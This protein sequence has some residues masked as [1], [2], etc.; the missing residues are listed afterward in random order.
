MLF[1]KLDSIT[2]NTRSTFE[3]NRAIKESKR[4]VQCNHVEPTNHSLDQM[5]RLLTS[6]RLA[7][8][9]GQSNGCW[10]KV[11]NDAARI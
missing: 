5:R 10:S 7:D 3:V 9:H 6:T 1:F 11:E 2:L 8:S 4:N